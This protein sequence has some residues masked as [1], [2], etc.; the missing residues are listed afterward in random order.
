MFFKNLTSPMEEV[1]AA[2][3]AGLSLTMSTGRLPKELLQNSLRP[4]LAS[5]GTYNRLHPAM[6]QVS[7]KLYSASL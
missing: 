6:L 3:R 1:H 5:L 4:L 2:A 7:P